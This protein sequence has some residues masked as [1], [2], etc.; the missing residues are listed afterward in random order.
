MGIVLLIWLYL[1]WLILLLGSSIAF[2]H[3]HGNHITR[4]SGFESSPQLLEKVGLDLMVRIAQAFESGRGPL[5][6]SEL[7]Q[8]KFV[9]PILTRK[10]TKR[11]LSSGLIVYAGE[12]G[13]GYVPGRSTDQ[14]SV[15][16]VLN[17]LRVDRSHLAKK[18]TFPDQLE[19]ISHDFQTQ[20][21][22]Q[23]GQLLLRELINSKQK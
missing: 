20:L 3:Q 1:N 19:Q 4:Q 8:Q 17:S 5:S 16:D 21:D 7:E 15:A 14:I 10:I 12:D 2:Y 13:D 9:P 18:L 23:F 11:L 22:E 6:Q